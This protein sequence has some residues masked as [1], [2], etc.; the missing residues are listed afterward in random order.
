MTAGFCRGKISAVL[1]PFSFTF[2]HSLYFRLTDL[3][4]LMCPWDF[5]VMFNLSS[6]CH[7]S[8][9]GN[10][11]GIQMG[12]IFPI[13]SGGTSGLPSAAGLGCYQ[14]VMKLS[15]AISSL[16]CGTS[17]EIPGRSTLQSRIS[18]TGATGHTER[19]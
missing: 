8:M 9:T 3:N 18:G 15:S 13:T 14:P 19:L 17:S 7:L 16:V 2:P 12:E 6:V 10:D 4:F 1:V 5:C 11:V